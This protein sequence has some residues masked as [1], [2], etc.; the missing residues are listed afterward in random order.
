MYFDGGN[1]PK[2]KDGAI[3]DLILPAAVVEEESAL[4]RLQQEHIVAILPINTKLMLGIRAKAVP[5][6]RRSSVT[7]P[8]ALSP[9][10]DYGF[11]EVQLREPLRLKLRGSKSAIL[12]SCEC[13]IPALNEGASSLN[14]AYTLI[15][16]VFEPDCLSHTGN[17]FQRG[18]YLDGK[19]WRP[20]S[21]LRSRYE[22]EFEDRL[23]PQIQKTL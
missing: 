16:E 1:L 3:G 18:Y 8:E 7:Y 12:E 9:H 5:A 17:I 10:V 14:H 2:L 13:Y 21:D 6:G 11:V 22:A 19:R 20:L 4:Q 15:S 23:R